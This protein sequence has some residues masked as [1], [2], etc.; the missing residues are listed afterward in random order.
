[1]A[2]VKTV[3]LKKKK[4][5]QMMRKRYIVFFQKKIIYRK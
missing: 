5:G 4:A 2:D 1:M 3:Q